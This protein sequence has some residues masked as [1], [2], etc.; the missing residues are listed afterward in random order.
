[1]QFELEVVGIDVIEV[2]WTKSFGRLTSP[3]YG[4]ILDCLECVEGVDKIELL[5][6]S[7]LVKIA[8]HLLSPELAVTILGNAILEDEALE[9]ALREEADIEK[10]FVKPV[11]PIKPAF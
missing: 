11:T 10:I 9:I 8:T 3:V 6:Y 4:A 2:R 7:A 5:R 1:M